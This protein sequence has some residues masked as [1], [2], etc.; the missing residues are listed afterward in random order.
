MGWEC[1]ECND[2][3]A[4]T[5]AVCHHCGKPLCVKDL[6]VVFDDAFAAVPKKATGQAA[7]CRKCRRE[8]HY[9][10]SVPLGKESR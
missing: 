5:V 6:V 2:H 8:Y 7:H 10:W 9:L 1:A 4:E 3:R